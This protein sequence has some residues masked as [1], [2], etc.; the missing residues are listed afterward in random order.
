MSVKYNGEIG[1]ISVTQTNFGQFIGYSQSKIS[2]MAAEGELVRDES[3][4]SGRI[5]LAESLRSYYLSTKATGD[6]VNYWKEK[7]KREQ[8]NRKIDE[9]KLRKLE[10]EVYEAATVEQGIIEILTTL[11]THLTALP[12]KFSLQLEG[13]SR[14]EIYR[15][16]TAEI[17]ER[18][19][20][21][22][23]GL[24]NSIAIE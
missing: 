3:D 6:G 17:E 12:A 13:R 9:I 2:Q 21:L 1:E 7:A 4:K 10:G 20:E 15:L 22:S 11:R 23:Q 5:M 19:E 14:E 16:M 18:L 24:K 8:V